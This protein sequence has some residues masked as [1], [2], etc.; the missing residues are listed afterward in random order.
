MRALLISNPNSTSLNGEVPREVV[1]ALMGATDLVSRF[2]EYA[3]HAEHIVQGL[4]RDDVDVVIIMGGDGS[5]NEV[6]NG[7]LGPDV[8]AR[9]H[10]EELPRLA[11]IPSGSANVFAR[12]LGYPNHPA[13][14]AKK[15]AGLLASDTTRILPAGRTADRWFIVNVGFGLDAAV[16]KGMEKLRGRGISA[17]TGVYG[18]IATRAWRQLRRFPPNIT[19]RIPGDALKATGADGSHLYQEGI[20][21]ADD[22]TLT[23]IPFTVVTNTNPWTYAG[24]LPIITNPDQTLDKALSLY[25]L[26]NISGIGGLGALLHTVG[27]ARQLLSGFDFHEREFRIDDVSTIHLSSAEPLPVQIDGESV[28]ET[29]QLTVTSIPRCIEVVADP[30]DHFDDVIGE[31]LDNSALL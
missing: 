11:V 28:E 17:T 31:V 5:V 9:P 23:D 6:L 3:G 8:E 7:L 27:A 2:T 26:H 30:A 21:V 12:A 10:P 16:I 29:T 20:H 15:L 13:A 14:A 1:P 25:A 24:A 4:T 18:A 22:V 19:I